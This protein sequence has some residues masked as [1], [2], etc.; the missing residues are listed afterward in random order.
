MHARAKSLI[1]RGLTTI[2]STLGMVQGE[3]KL[4]TVNPGRFQTNPRRATTL[5]RPTNEL[6]VPGRGVRKHRQRHAAAP[7]TASHTPIP[8]NPHPPQ[9]GDLLHGGSR[10][11]LSSRSPDL[12]PLP[13]RPCDAD[14]PVC[15]TPRCAQRRRGADLT[16]KVQAFRR[17]RPPRRN[18]SFRRQL[19]IPA[20]HSNSIYKA[21]LE[22]CSNMRAYWCHR[23][24][25]VVTISIA[26]I[27]Q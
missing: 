26:G 7:R 3:R 14:S 12:A 2:T 27:S 16:Y 15:D 9:L 17:Q 22:R 13:N 23:L 21:S 6:L 11:T 1:A 19:A 24:P 25:R 5:G 20:N 8:S 18:N 10:T 4:Q